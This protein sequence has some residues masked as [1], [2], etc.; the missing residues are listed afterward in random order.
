MAA[1]RP[2]FRV[3]S[4]TVTLG[5]DQERHFGPYTYNANWGVDARS[6]GSVRH[7]FGVFNDHE[8]QRRRAIAAQRAGRFPFPFGS[9]RTAHHLAFNAT[10]NGQLYVVVRVGVFNPGGGM[11]T[12]VLDIG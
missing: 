8:Y 9:D 3:L 7:Y 5:S 4:Q 11:I 1:G 10:Q 2:L 6:F 12:V